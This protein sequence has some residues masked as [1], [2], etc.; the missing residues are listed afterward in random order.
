MFFT[1]SKMSNPESITV[2][3]EKAKE[4]RE[5]GWEQ[6]KGYENY[7]VNRQGQVKRI[8]S[9]RD[10]NCRDE[11]ILKLSYTRGYA[12]VSLSKDDKKKNYR[13]ARLVAETFIPNPD[14]KPEV[15]HI[16]GD[17]SNDDV[18]NLEW[19]TSKENTQHAIRL[20]LRTTS[21]TVA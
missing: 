19:C 12:H 9:N 17:P 4:L 18:C 1:L 5:A 10:G 16:D 20:G 21:P 13:I 7:F 14:N 15:N 2:S 3:L 6:V 8:Y 11:R